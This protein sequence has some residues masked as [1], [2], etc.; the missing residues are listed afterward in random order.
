MGKRFERTLHN[1]KYINGQYA[2]IKTPDITNDHGN[3]NKTT[4]R[5]HLY[6]L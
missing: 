3:A 1:T 4:M 6:A 2:F 5:D